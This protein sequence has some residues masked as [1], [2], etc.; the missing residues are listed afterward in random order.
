MTYWDRE[1]IVKDSSFS[2]PLIIVNNECTNAFGIMKPH[3]K[4]ENYKKV[5][6][7]MYCLCGDNMP[8]TSRHHMYI[9]TKPLDNVDYICMC[10]ITCHLVSIQ[11]F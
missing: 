4:S 6:S 3:L 1:H 9:G 11:S 10:H 8:F 2:S 7:Y 5:K